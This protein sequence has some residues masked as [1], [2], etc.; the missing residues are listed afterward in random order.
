MAAK[1]KGKRANANPAP[2]PRAAATSESTGASNGSPSVSK[3]ARVDPEISSEKRAPKA[4]P[5]LPK[6]LPQP[7]FPSEASPVD[8]PIAIAL[9]MAIALAVMVGLTWKKG[10]VAAAA[11]GPESAVPKASFLVAKVDVP[12]LRASPI[13]SIVS[14]D[15]G[16]GKSL[17]LDELSRGCGF[18]PLGR[19]DDL[20]L[21]I[22]EGEARGTFGVAAQVRITESELATCAERISLARGT[23]T[24]P[25][26]VGAFHVLEGEKGERGQP[27]LAFREGGL[28]VVA[29]GSW[30]GSMLAAAEGTEPRA[31]TEDAH[32][33]LVKTLTA[34]PSLAHPTVLATALLPTALRERLKSELSQELASASAGGND[35]GPEAIMSAV[36]SV[37]A[38]GLAISARAGEELSAMAVLRCESEANAKVL[39]RLVERKRFGWQ[40]D[41]GIRLIGLGAVVDSITAEPK[42]RELDVRLHAPIDDLARGIQRAMDYGRKKAQPEPG[43]TPPPMKKPIP[44]EILPAKKDAGR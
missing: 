36:L 40:K 39:A 27:G 4:F 22:P 5:A 25:K 42:G 2:K 9:V 7:A 12:T 23:K 29:E 20:V 24:S 21:A 37:G 30:L 43:P 15:D 44:D 17:G 13:Y 31:L 16:A 8:N 35:D 10:G 41:I 11:L 34:E 18:D 1:K 28:L 26:V 19:V 14:G 3:R 6:P 33:E 38:A 32:A